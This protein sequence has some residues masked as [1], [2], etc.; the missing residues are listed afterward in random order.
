MD[1]AK[2]IHLL[3][4]TTRAISQGVNQLLTEHGLYSSEW[5]MIVALK[6][7]GPITQNALANYLS[8]EPAAISKTIV[9]LEEKGLVERKPGN[10]KREKKVFLTDHALN[11]YTRWETTVDTHRRALLADLTKEEQDTL[12]KML[13]SIYANSQKHKK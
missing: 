12:S 5:S 8:I 1:A 6:E 3:F 7:T 9:K 10:D 13:Q 4:Q 11:H 2:L